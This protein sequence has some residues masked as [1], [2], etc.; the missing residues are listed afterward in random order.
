MTKVT[1][2]HLHFYQAEQLHTVLGAT[3]RHTF[4][5]NQDR[6]L[7]EQH[8]I[9][10]GTTHL[11]A[12]DTQGSILQA[13]DAQGTNPLSYTAFGHNP[14]RNALIALT[15]FNGE[16]RD[17]QT[18]WYLLGS[19]YRAFNPERMRFNSPDSYSPFGT[20]G[21]N[22]YMYCEGDPVN[23]VDPSGHSPLNLKLAS[24]KRQV[25]QN[26]HRVKPA[27]FV[28]PSA[29]SPWR[30][31]PTAVVDQGIYRPD[32]T[33]EV[34]LREKINDKIAKGHI[35]ENARPYSKDYINYKKLIRSAAKLIIEVKG[36]EPQIKAN[37]KWFFQ[38]W[39][40]LGHSKTRTNITNEVAKIRKKRMQTTNRL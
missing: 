22:A 10:P 33:R 38:D 17:R 26:P 34:H 24:V 28:D 3:T 14:E 5:R 18:G 20:G 21:I 2:T 27:N 40:Q 32:R 1:G 23:F 6:P 25:I 31:R 29:N 7:A 30:P 11:L 36:Y 19:G 13:Q 35:V 15:G 8:G 16:V 12:T 39:P 4:F 9:G 37:H